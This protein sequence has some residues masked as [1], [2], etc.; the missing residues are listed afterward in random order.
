MRKLA[1]LLAVAVAASTP[2]LAFAAKKAKKAKAPETMESL[3]KDS[4]KA[5]HDFFIWPSETKKK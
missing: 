3:N 1:L 4:I 5:F 2:S